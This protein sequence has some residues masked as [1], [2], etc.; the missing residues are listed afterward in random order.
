MLDRLA[1]WPGSSSLFSA[2]WVHAQDDSTTVVPVT[3]TYA[4]ESVERIQFFSSFQDLS[5]DGPP[6]GPSHHAACMPYAARPCAHAWVSPAWPG[7]D[8]SGCN[9]CRLV[10]AAV[11]V[12]VW[13][14]H[15]EHLQPCGESVGPGPPA[16]RR[17]AQRPE[18]VLRPCRQRRESG[19]TA[20]AQG[21]APLTGR[22]LLR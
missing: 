3:V 1:T 8:C 2:E 9:P 7:A 10:H 12:P 17:A 16:D 13:L 11:L 22:C 21:L 18:R 15:R 14:E 20:A 19:P 6:G 4:E 5:A